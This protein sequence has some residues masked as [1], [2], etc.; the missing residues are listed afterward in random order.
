[1]RTLRLHC[2]ILL[3]L[4]CR[5][6][7]CAQQSDNPALVPPPDD[8]YKTDILVVI[9]HPDD[10]TAITGYLARAIF[11]E[12]KRVAVV[13]GTRGNSGGNAVGFEQ[14]ASL[15]AVREI[16][17]RRALASFGITNVWFL[18]APDTPGQDVL[19]SLETWNHGSSLDQTVRLIRL[20]RPE[21]ILT[22]LPAYSAGEN[23]GDHQA[24]GV[25]ATEAF[26]LAGDPTVFPEQVTAPRNRSSIA[27][28]TEGLHAWQPQKL[29]YF[30][31]AAHT[32]FLAGKG[33]VYS[34]TDV[35]KS[36]GMPYYKLIAEQMSFHLTQ[37]D[38]G[39]FAANA[40]K[41]GDLKFFR[42]PVRFVFGK[43]VVGG[44]AADDIFQGVRSGPIAFVRDPGYQASNATGL[45]AEFGG[46]WAFYKQFWTAHGL[47]HLS[48]LLA[49]EVGIGVASMLSIPVLVHNRTNQDQMISI[50][51]TLPKGWTLLSK[52]PRWSIPPRADLPVELYFKTPDKV[53]ADWQT[54]QINVTPTRN[55]DPI[56]LPLKV[57]LTATA[58]PQ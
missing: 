48:N 24:A 20:T 54:I 29:Y 26:G 34:T 55:A 28:L 15:A 17:G 11:D 21:V 46:P 44:S 25:I 4:L 53:G 58:L 1:M 32:E 19:R 49:P 42:E 10:E 51:A 22:W 35:S 40:L 13:Y 36:K 45:S 57:N 52:T 43:S 47:D 5:I 37:D 8:R 56:R 23:H 9:A 7:L 41:S 30:T 18:G 12:H 38:T 14:A 16:E 6:S 27:N 31:D 33:P 39:Q 50:G 2:F 3:G